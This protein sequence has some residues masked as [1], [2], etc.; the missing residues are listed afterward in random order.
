MAA[1]QVKY[2]ILLT[3]AFASFFA[4]FIW[5]V[6]NLQYASRFFPQLIAL[7]A[8]V[9][10]VVQIG[11]EFRQR[12]TLA[13]SEALRTDQRLASATS[14][15][16]RPKLAGSTHSLAGAAPVIEEAATADIQSSGRRGLQFMALYLGFIGLI[17]LLGFAVAAPLFLAVFLVLVARSRWSGVALALVG[18]AAGYFA[19]TTFADMV[20][21]PRGY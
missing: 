19:L 15:A 1:F 9:L 5:S 13:A 17:W 20:L 3:V 18:Y 14:S 8:L 2:R 6:R 16:E 21:P 12:S 4:Y 7:I 10:A 11:L